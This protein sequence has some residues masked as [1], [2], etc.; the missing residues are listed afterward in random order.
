[1]TLGLSILIVIGFYVGKRFY[2]KPGI[3]NGV[4]AFEINGL[5]S[6]GSSFSLSDLRGKYVLL[7]FWGSWC[8]PCRK[9]HPEMVRIYKKYNQQDFEDASGFE[10][11]S[12]SL[13]QNPA[14]WKKAIEV[15]SL[16]WPYHLV[17]NQMFDAPVLKNYNVKQLPTSFLINP[18]GVIIAVDP[19]LEGVRK[20]L[21]G[22]V[23]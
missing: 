7:D 23:K 6:D 11:V 17:T 13:E 5:L 10:I 1:M 8:N 9:A 18:E 16:T 22:K 15:D 14:N 3:K 21:E 12:F 2:L 19:S 4:K 20:V